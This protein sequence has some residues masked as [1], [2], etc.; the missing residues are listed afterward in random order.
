M[1]QGFWRWNSSNARAQLIFGL[2]LMLTFG[3]LPD[4]TCAGASDLVREEDFPNLKIEEA[5]LGLRAQ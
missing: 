1:S 4:G 2:E 3:W 5:S